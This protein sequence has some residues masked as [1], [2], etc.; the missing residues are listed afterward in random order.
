MIKRLM[1]V[2]SL[3]LATMQQAS[4]AVI[5]IWYPLCKSALGSLNS[6]VRDGTEKAGALLELGGMSQ[7]EV[8]AG[9]NKV[10]DTRTAI[11]TKASNLL[12]YV[13]LGEQLLETLDQAK[14]LG[15]E[16]E[17]ICT[18]MESVRVD[19]YSPDAVRRGNM[20]MQAIVKQLPHVV[21][22][23]TMCVVSVA[24]RANAREMQQALGRFNA[25]VAQLR[26]RIRALA[27][28]IRH[29]L[30]RPQARSEAARQWAKEIG[31]ELAKRAAEKWGNGDIKL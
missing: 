9:T 17:G 31:R 28:W 25:A 7:K 18:L 26:F 30:I 27:D 3:L 4:P 19:L 22:L 21:H 5:H 2:A 8:M 11:Y 20:R 16:V 13:A 14:Q 29:V 12:Q 15:H 1:I 10:N 6:V 24:M 23:G